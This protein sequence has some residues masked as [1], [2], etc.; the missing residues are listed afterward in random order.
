LDNYSFRLPFHECAFREKVAYNPD[1]FAEVKNIAA[2]LFKH[3][4]ISSTNEFAQHSSRVSKRAIPK[5]SFE[6]TFQ[7]GLIFELHMS[8]ALKNLISCSSERGKSK[9]SRLDPT[10]GSIELVG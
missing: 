1:A 9:R 6:N 7:G 5:S 4:A 8:P 10:P 2:D 3:P